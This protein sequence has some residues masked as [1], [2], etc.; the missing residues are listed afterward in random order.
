MA[1]TIAEAIEY[2]L[3]HKVDLE[4][5]VEVLLEYKHDPSP[6]LANSPIREIEYITVKEA[7]ELCR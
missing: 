4:M 2:S 5:A 1:P 3:K 6:E 7:I